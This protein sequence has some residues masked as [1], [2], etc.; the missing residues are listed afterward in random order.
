[1]CRA[2][3]FARLARTVSGVCHVPHLP[4]LNGMSRETLVSEQFAGDD[5]ASS[6]M[7]ICWTPHAPQAPVVPGVNIMDH[8]RI[9]STS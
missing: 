9:T 7:K 5:P 3:E 2:N 8:A 1:M 6:I 4:L